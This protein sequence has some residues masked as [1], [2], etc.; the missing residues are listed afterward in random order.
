MTGSSIPTVICESI[1]A[2][3]S[4][5]VGVR[6]VFTNGCFDVLHVGHIR[7]L[8]MA[9]KLGDYLIVGLNSD[10][11]VRRLKGIERPI[12]TWSKRAEALSAIASVDCIIKF[13]EDTPLTLIETLR[14]DVIAKGGDYKMDQMIGREFV[15]NYGG[16]VVILPYYKGHSTTEMINQRKKS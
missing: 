4:Q 11:S 9:K 7:T 8:E 6:I 16:D 1:E 13:E 2:Y 12:N 10:N 15:K 3:Q 14:P 5:P